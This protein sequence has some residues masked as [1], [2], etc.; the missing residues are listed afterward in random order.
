L[1]YE[2]FDGLKT[3]KKL[4][5]LA[6]F[7]RFLLLYKAEVG[8][9]T[10]SRKFVGIDVAKDKLDIAVL[11]EKNASQVGNDEKGGSPNSSRSCTLC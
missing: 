9:T 1:V 11:G 4:F 7:V 6:F 2:I 5:F 10:S 8:M 3:T